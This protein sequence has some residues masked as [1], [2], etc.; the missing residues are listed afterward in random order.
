MLCV[1]GITY[2]PCTQLRDFY[3][4]RTLQERLFPLVCSYTLK[5]VVSDNA[6]G[7]T[8]VEAGVTVQVKHL[9][10]HEMQHAAPLTL[11]APS[12]GVVRPGTEVGGE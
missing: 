12:W 5:I 3:T 7:Q 8:N 11:A 6:H 4:E 1:Y 2:F 9:T 10:S